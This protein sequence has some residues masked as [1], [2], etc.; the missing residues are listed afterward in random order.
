MSTKK[1]ITMQGN[2]GIQRR[3]FCKHASSFAESRLLDG[4]DSCI[5]AT[6]PGQTLCGITL[7]AEKQN[8]PKTCRTYSSTGFVIELTNP[9]H[10][11]GLDVGS[12]PA[13]DPYEFTNECF[14]TSDEVCPFTFDTV[15]LAALIIRGLEQGTASTDYHIV[16]LLTARQWRYVPYPAICYSGLTAEQIESVKRKA[17]ISDMKPVMNITR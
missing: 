10:R 16:E 3:A 12:V 13:T 1:H 2:V 7:K 6:G 15:G 14:K 4:L 5:P 17:G 8:M 11:D 9:H